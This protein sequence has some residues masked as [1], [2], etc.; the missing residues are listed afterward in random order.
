MKSEKIPKRA[1][2][3]TKQNSFRLTK[4]ERNRAGEKVG[5]RPLGESSGHDGFPLIGGVEDN[6]PYYE[7]GY[8]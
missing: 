5:R 1:K 7:L 3:Q 6:N 8:N 4:A 2:Q